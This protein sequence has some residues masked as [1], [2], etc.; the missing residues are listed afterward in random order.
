[1]P[2]FLAIALL[3][4]QGECSIISLASEIFFRCFSLE[5]EITDDFFESLVFSPE[6]LEFS[7]GSG[8]VVGCSPKPSSNRVMV[9]IVGLR[10]FLNRFAIIF[11]DGKNLGLDIRRDRCRHMLFRLTEGQKKKRH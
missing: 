5:N 3:E 10:R 8:G 2:K 1:M 11:D 9:E 6:P 7:T 4:S